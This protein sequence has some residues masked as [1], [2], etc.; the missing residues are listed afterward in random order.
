V[1]EPG[2]APRVKLG[3]EIRVYTADATALLVSPA[4]TATASSVSVELTVMGPVYAVEEVL[5]ILPS[6]V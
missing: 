3:G 4:R 6:V 5:G 2:D 1:S